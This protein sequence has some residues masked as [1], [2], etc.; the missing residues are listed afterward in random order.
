MDSFR[1]QLQANAAQWMSRTASTAPKS[2][3]ISHG[4]RFEPEIKVSKENVAPV[5]LRATTVVS[6]PSVTAA[7]DAHTDQDEAKIPPITT[8][9]PSAESPRSM[10]VETG[11]NIRPSLKVDPC[12]LQ[13]SLLTLSRKSK[14]HSLSNFR[15]SRRQGLL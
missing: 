5:V 2:P 4:T 12:A 3:A 8:D 15:N 10:T 13:V 7:V 9:T 1:A 11:T 6:E 14:S